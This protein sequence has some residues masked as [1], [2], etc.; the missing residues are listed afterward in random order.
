MESIPGSPGIADNSAAPAP[1]FI[2]M[3]GATRPAAYE[4]ETNL[5]DQV[6]A[7]I[8]PGKLQRKLELLAGT[9]R[10]SSLYYHLTSK[11]GRQGLTI[12]ADD[13]GYPPPFLK[14]GF[15]IDAQ[16]QDWRVRGP[17]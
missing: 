9:E 7:P 5:A 11:K 15:L 13:N 16:R 10:F 14:L 17:I 1:E 6:G 2:E 4:N 3:T 12:H 8:D